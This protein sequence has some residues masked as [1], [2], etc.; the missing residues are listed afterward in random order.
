LYNKPARMVVHCR[1]N[2]FEL[3]T[4]KISS[5]T[6]RVVRK[7]YVWERPNSKLYDY[8]YEIGGLYY[9]PMINYIVKRGANGPRQVVDIPDRMLSN[10]D[11]RAYQ[12]KPQ[13]VDLED[14]LTESYKRRTKD[15][16]GKY[17]H[18]AN[19]KVRKSKLSTDL[20]LYRGS[21][22]I[23]DKYLCQLQLY[24]TGQQ[25]DSLIKD[26][27]LDIYE[28]EEDTSYGPG[29][30]RVK[31]SS[32]PTREVKVSEMLDD[33]NLKEE[34]S[35]KNMRKENLV[36]LLNDATK[37]AIELAEEVKQ[38]TKEEREVNEKAASTYMVAKKEVKRIVDEKRRQVEKLKPGAMS[39]DVTYSGRPIDQLGMHER[40]AL[41]S[42]Q[43]K[44]RKLPD[45]DVG[46]EVVERAH[47][48]E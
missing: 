2:Q 46:Y 35:L 38:L 44:P 43:Y 6:K 9:Q 13:E 47:Y 40:V 31:F 30:T 20:N 28:R 3:N 45:F 36:G 19:E 21:A 27:D 18:V 32:K 37:Q 17:V 11:R 5:D 12:L 14:F 16:N 7:P 22:C 26:D 1:D 33:L 39:V 10:Y 24:H 42:G 8:H 34:T 41:K 48:L 29:Y 25:K 4:L 15:I 23:R